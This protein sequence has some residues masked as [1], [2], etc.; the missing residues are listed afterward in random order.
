M[1]SYRYLRGNISESFENVIL[2]VLRT[3]PQETI[4][5]ASVS[6]GADSTAMLAALASIRKNTPP[7]ISIRCIHVEHGIRPE[8]ERSGDAEF[9]R[10]L[11]RRL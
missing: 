6:G 9:V 8:A 7:P 3:F 1:S 2:D 11:C 10:S 4:F 5:L